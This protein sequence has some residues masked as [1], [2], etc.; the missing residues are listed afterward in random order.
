MTKINEVYKCNVCG[1][2][3][4]IFHSGMGELTCCNK[5]MNI[6]KENTV[7]AAK[8]K[9][10]PFFQKTGNK[11]KITVGEINHPM[12]ETH[13]IEWIEVITLN[14]IFRKK[15]TPNDEPIAEFEINS[16]VISV[17]AYCNLHGL[18]S[19]K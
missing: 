11:I 3:I 10:I 7:E 2:I 5:A 13:F 18:W 1:N 9:H 8:E 4:E 19:N 16:E 17:R 6:Q 15:L 14:K 12:E